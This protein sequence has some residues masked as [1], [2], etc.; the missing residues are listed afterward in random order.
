MCKSCLNAKCSTRP[1]RWLITQQRR[2]PVP[3]EMTKHNVCW[4]EPRK[5]PRVELFKEEASDVY[6][7]GRESTHQGGVCPQ[8]KLMRSWK[9]SSRRV[10]QQPVDGVGRAPEEQSHQRDDQAVVRAGDGER[11]RVKSNMSEVCAGGA[12]TRNSQQ[13]CRE[14]SSDI[15]STM[16]ASD[17][18]V[19]KIVAVLNNALLFR[20]PV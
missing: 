11:D 20:I 8:G 2:V 19:N 13:Q 17:T 14:L 12:L 16:T 1:H 18:D 3:H 7:Q 10:S 6:A 9:Q 4:C 15:V 5:Y